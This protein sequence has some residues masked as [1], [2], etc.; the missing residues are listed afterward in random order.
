MVLFYSRLAHH[1]P[2]PAHKLHITSSCHC[3]PTSL[4]T[5][6]VP[7]CV[8]LPHAEACKL[9]CFSQPLTLPAA[10]PTS[11]LSQQVHLQPLEPHPVYSSPRTCCCVNVPSQL[12][13]HIATSSLLSPCSYTRYKGQRG[14]ALPSM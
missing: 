13:P 2:R 6:T 1:F 8:F 5:T 7:N 11:L 4:A 12:F 10:W 9:V 14:K 3:R